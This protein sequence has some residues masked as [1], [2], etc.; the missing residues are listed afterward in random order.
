MLPRRVQFQN[1]N[2]TWLPHP[3]Y[4]D[5]ALGYAATLTFNGAWPITFW[6]QC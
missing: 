4:Q 5:G 1:S 6:G 3:D 2:L